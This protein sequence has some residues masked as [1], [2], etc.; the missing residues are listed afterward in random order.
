MM[1]PLS[2]AVTLLP[3]PGILLYYRAKM[4]PN[5]SRHLHPV[6][7]IMRLASFQEATRPCQDAV[8]TQVIFGSSHS[9]KVRRQDASRSIKDFPG[10]REV[11]CIVHK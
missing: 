10:S 9:S 6:R 3:L 2:P 7:A 5:H 1:S 11:K 4:I 8:S